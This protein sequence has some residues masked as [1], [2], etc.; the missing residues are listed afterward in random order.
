MWIY[1][2]N[3]Y[4]GNIHIH[5]VATKFAT[6]QNKCV[7]YFST[8][9]YMKV[10]KIQCYFTKHIKTWQTTVILQGSKCSSYAAHLADDA[11]V[12]ICCARG[13]FFL[14][15]ST[16][17]SIMLSLSSASKS[18]TG[19]PNVKNLSHILVICSSVRNRQIRKLWT[20]FET[21]YRNCILWYT[22]QKKYTASMGST[23]WLWMMQTVLI[24]S[25]Q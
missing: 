3:P 24:P 5:K 23:Y 8:V 21:S 6:T 25:L 14:E 9:H 7:V 11:D 17:V 20:E 16:L 10:H 15:D 12:P 22:A 1:M 19:C 13:T 2:W 18:P 4:G